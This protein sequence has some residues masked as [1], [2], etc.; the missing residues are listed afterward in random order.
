MK[1][2]LGQ[3][4]SAALWREWLGLVCAFLWFFGS[5]YSYYEPLFAGA[6]SEPL[7]MLLLCAGL[8]VS[9][10]LGGKYPES[11]ERALPYATLAGAVCTGIIPFLPGFA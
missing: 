10:F 8:L 9:S 3:N 2:Y 6:W 4:A 7:F 5:M 11:L 1:R